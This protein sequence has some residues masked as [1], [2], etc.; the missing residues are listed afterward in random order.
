MDK[1]DSSSSEKELSK[2]SSYM[3]LIDYAT[4]PLV[5]EEIKFFSPQ[6][7]RD[8]TGINHIIKPI[9]KN[10]TL[11][12]A[13]AYIFNNNPVQIAGVL[14]AYQDRMPDAINLLKAI[15]TGI[16]ERNICL[17]CVRNNM[18]LLLKK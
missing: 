8:H 12:D 14:Q 2:K 5:A 3:N 1:P 16:K 4:E 10:Y 18:E 7:V 13:L 17:T 11:I 15:E 6:L 9:P